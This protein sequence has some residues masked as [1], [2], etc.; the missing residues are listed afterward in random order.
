MTRATQIGRGTKLL[1]FD[2]QR[3]ALSQAASSGTTTTD[4]SQTTDTTAVTTT[5]TYAP[6]GVGGSIAVQGSRAWAG[7]TSTA[8]SSGDTIT[9]P[10]PGSALIVAQAV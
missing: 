2:V 9:R 3:S 5:G 10:V 1:R 7:G 6:G 8:R 4:S